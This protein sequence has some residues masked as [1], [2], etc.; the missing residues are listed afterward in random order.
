MVIPEAN[1]KKPIAVYGVCYVHEEDTIM[2]YS[3]LEK[4]EKRERETERRKQK[5]HAWSGI[6]AAVARRNQSC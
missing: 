3:L 6:T 1:C 5:C 4:R 2:L